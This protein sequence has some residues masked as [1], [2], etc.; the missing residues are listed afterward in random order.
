MALFEGIATSIGGKLGAGKL[1]A[2]ASDIPVKIIR[3]KVQRTILDKTKNS[4]SKRIKDRGEKSFVKNLQTGDVSDNAKNEVR[5]V[6]SNEQQKEIDDAIKSGLDKFFNVGGN[7]RR[8]GQQRTIPKIKEEGWIPGRKQKNIE[9]VLDETDNLSQ[10]RQR[11][12]EAFWNTG[13][14]KTGTIGSSALGTGY[15]TSKVVGNKNNNEAKV[16]AV[17]ETK[18]SIPQKQ[19]EQKIIS[20]KNEK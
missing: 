7:V 4:V 16:I 10:M 12:R 11:E 14:V 2:A 6:I 20:N 1:V 19:K 18:P 17:S 8:A 13:I 3:G 5:K 15:L 9:Y